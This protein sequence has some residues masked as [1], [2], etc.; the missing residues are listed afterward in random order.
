MCPV[1]MKNPKCRKSKSK[2]RRGCF[3]YFDIKI[4]K[5]VDMFG[6]FL[7]YLKVRP[8]CYLYEDLIGSQSYP[9]MLFYMQYLHC[10]IEYCAQQ[11]C[12]DMFALIANLKALICRPCFYFVL[13]TNLW[14]SVC[15]T[16]WNLD[17][18]L[19]SKWAVKI[20]TSSSVR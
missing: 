19:A 14:V 17:M 16:L 7:K 5:Y 10:V 4:A 20:Y 1:I 9:S 18:Y 13:D 12:F 6:I 11:T 15:T 3:H 2:L 8:L